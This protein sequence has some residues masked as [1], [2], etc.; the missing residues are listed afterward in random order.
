MPTQQTSNYDYI[1][2]GAGSAGR[3]IAARLSQDPDVRVALVEAGG[4]DSADEIRLMNL[5]A[6]IAAQP[7]FRALLRDPFY[8]GINS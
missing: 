4:P 2:V 6:E 8:A 7:A 3:V 5:M 1:I